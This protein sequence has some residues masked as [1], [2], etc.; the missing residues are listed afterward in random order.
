MNVGVRRQK[1]LIDRSGLGLLPGIVLAFLLALIVMAALL[2]EAWWVTFG[3]LVTLFGLTGV[4]V[5]VVLK[6]ADEG[7]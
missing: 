5:W 2:F 4:V 3:V 1:Q 6:M 7:P